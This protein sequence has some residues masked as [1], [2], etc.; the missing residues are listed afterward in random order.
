MALREALTAGSMS[1]DAEYI[2]LS[3]TREPR[4]SAPGSC[5]SWASTT[6]I[7]DQLVPPSPRPE[8][9]RRAVH[10]RLTGPVARRN[11]CQ[12]QPFADSPATNYDT[13]R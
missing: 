13:L 10:H 3:L 11:P 4:A 8:D 2:L 7:D 6:R 12:D 5:S 9:P 1:A